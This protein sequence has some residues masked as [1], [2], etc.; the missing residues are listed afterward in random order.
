MSVVDHGMS[1]EEQIDQWRSFLGRRDAIRSVDVAELEDHLR[2]QVADLVGKGLA[3]DEAFMVAVKR[4]GDLDALAHEYAL[5]HSERLWKQL[6]VPE[7]TGESRLGIPTNAFVAV[8]LAVVA[9]V[10]VK[11]PVLF[12]LRLDHDASFYGRNASLF[13]LPL[14]TGYFAWKTT[15]FQ[16]HRSLAGAR[17]RRGGS[18]RQRLSIYQSRFHRDSDGVA[19]A[20]P[21]LARG[22]RGLR[23]QSL[24]SRKWAD[25][26]HPVH[27]RALHLLRADCARRRSLHWVPGDDVHDDWDQAET[28]SSNRGCCRAAQWAR[29]WSPPGW[30][31]PSRA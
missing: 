19:F 4:I 21:P 5:E 9:A 11:A 7:E 2:E 13:V 1:L 31:R 17:V 24:G 6:V 10:A 18:I 22:W 25:G 3:S 26:L 28:R 15:T 23:R 14:L 27:G 8:C 12:G 30:W 29:Y 20:D 16:Q